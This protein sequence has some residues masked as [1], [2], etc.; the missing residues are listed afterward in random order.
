MPLVLTFNVSILVLMDS[1]ASG[2][3]VVWSGCTDP[4]CAGHATYTPSSKA[5]N[6][7]Y[8]DQEFYTED[9]LEFDSWRMNDTL[10]YGNVSIPVTFGAAFKLPDEETWDGNF[11]IAKSVFVGGACGPNYAGFVESA[12]LSGAIN[13]P[14]LAYYTVSLVPLLHLLVY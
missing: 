5:F 9:G 11:G 1:G 4:L 7:S 3:W 12:Y 10:T 13:A 8:I 6:F 14:V 2:A